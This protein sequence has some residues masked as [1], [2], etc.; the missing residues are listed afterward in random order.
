MDPGE[1]GNRLPFAQHQ[2]RSHRTRGR[3]PRRPRASG[4]PR[5]VPALS[6]VRRR[7]TRRPTFLARG[8][9]AGDATADHRTLSRNPFADHAGDDRDAGK[10]AL[11]LAGYRIR[12]PVPPRSR[13]QFSAAVS[14]RAGAAERGKAPTKDSLSSIRRRRGPGRGGIW[15]A[16]LLG[17]L[18]TP[19]SWGE[20]EGKR[21]AR[22]RRDVR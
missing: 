4:Q 7:A 18:P 15:E 12:P 19:A 13:H 1:S 17:P 11:S 5:Q 6:P 3:V 8:G 2:W 21:A 14:K 20:E 10:S 9:L 22:N 16:P